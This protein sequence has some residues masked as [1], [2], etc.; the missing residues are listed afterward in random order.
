M[1]RQQECANA[2]NQ[3]YDLHN[4]N[5]STDCV[6]FNTGLPLTWIVVLCLIAIVLGLGIWWSTRRRDG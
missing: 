3:G 2:T 6:L 1:T 5:H 4:V